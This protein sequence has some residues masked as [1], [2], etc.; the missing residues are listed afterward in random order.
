[1]AAEPTAGFAMPPS[2]PEPQQRVA[3]GLGITLIAATIFGFVTPLARFSYDYGV[4][5][6]T[7]ALFPIALGAVAAAVIVMVLP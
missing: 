5:P 1:M 4:N 7:A 6:S 2:A 3:L